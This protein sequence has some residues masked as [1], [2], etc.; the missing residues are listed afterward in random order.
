MPK[1]ELSLAPKINGQAS[2]RLFAI[3]DIITIGA[4]KNCL[5][6][7][8]KKFVLRLHFGDNSR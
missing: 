1:R 2:V 7:R 5:F 8:L 3:P 6:W 4:G